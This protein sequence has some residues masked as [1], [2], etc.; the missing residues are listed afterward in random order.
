MKN[1]F[2][3]CGTHLC[4]GIY[5]FYQSGIIDDS[6]E[7]HT[8]EANPECYIEDRIKNIPLNI[9]A[10]NKAIWINDG[11]LLFSQE[12][13]FK[14]N[15]GS[16]KDGRSNKDGWA[17]SVMSLGMKCDGY[18]TPVEVDCIDFSSFIYSLNPEDKIICKMD[19]EGSEYKVLPHL[20]E[21]KAIQR[22]KKLYIEF[23]SRFFD[24]IT[25]ITDLELTN[26]I[27][28]LGTEVYLWD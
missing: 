27:T 2:L 25:P 8:F 21:T 10:Y 13:H 18:E 23:H 9:T 20:I 6:Y 5:K 16:P 1:I 3:D 19:I 11:K 17:S 7:I 28:K 26:L 12:N 4:E 24:Y 22:I 14:N 15:S